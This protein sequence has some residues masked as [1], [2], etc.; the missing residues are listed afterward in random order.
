MAYEIGTKLPDPNRKTFFRYPLIIEDDDFRACHVIGASGEGKS[1]LLAHIAEQSLDQGEGVLLIDPKG[2]L[3][4]DFVARTEHTD[5]LIYCAPGAMA[6]PYWTL[7]PFEY[8]AGFADRK[9]I[10]DIIAGNIVRLFEHLGRLDQS[11]MTLVRTYLKGSI[12]LALSKPNPTLFDVLLILVSPGYRDHLLAQS[13]HAPSH[14]FWADYD[15]ETARDQRQ[16]IRS[17]K[18]RLF[19]FI[20]SPYL[21]HWISAPT[22]TF[23]FVEWLNEGKVVVCNFAR[24]LAEDDGVALG[25]LVMAQLCL[26]YR[27]R[28]AGMTSWNRDR[29]WRVIV[30][31]FHE[32]SPAP[33]ARVMTQGRGFNV[34]SVVAHQTDSQ[35]QGLPVL[36]EAAKQ[37]PI[38]VRCYVSSADRARIRL[39]EGQEAAEQV[40]ALKRFEALVDHRGPKGTSRTAVRLQDWWRE[41][42]EA[43]VAEALHL[44]RS[45]PYSMPERDLPRLDEVIAQWLP[46]SSREKME[47]DARRTTTHNRTEAKQKAKKP[48]AEASAQDEPRDSGAAS[49]EP[50]SEADGPTNRQT[51]FVPPEAF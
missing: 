43:Q 11:F 16:L 17:S 1:T 8:M 30:D 22:S 15:S 44:Q 36:T 29:R 4:H 42:D 34:F 2:D 23:R 37:V 38:F 19:D 49:D 50:I 13:R 25:N 40:A 6:D 12:R 47:P 39:E 32:L 18:N 35:L 14:F 10:S 21:R 28:E 45:H 51:T 3:A 26:E 48:R 20:W 24:G 9:G 41:A 7:N 27:L 5:K 46:Q 31:E 33:F